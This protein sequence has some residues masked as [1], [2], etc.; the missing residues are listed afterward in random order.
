MCYYHDEPIVIDCVPRFELSYDCNGNIVVT[1]KSL[2]RNGYAIPN[3]TFTTTIA[4]VNYSVILVYPYMSGQI[5]INNPTNATYTVTMTMDG[6]DCTCSESITLEPDPIIN[7]VDI[8][9]YMCEK[10]P[11]QFSA[12]VSGNNNL[13]YHWSFGDDSYNNG[14]GIYHSF[15]YRYAPYNILLTVTNSLGCQA[16]ATSTIIIR[17]QLEWGID[18]NRNTC[19]SW[20]YKNNTIQSTSS[21]EFVCVVI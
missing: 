19:L 7:S 20:K 6:S 11:F 10:T 9:S 21:T 15:A 5:N 16:T 2:Y 18:S 13:Q 1:D 4:G 17:E 14:N 8:Q 3:R 12:N